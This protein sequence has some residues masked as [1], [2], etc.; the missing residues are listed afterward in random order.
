MTFEIRNSLGRFCAFAIAFA[1]VA[2]YGGTAL[3]E[4]TWTAPFPGVWHLHRG[5]TD[6][7]ENINVLAVELCHPGISFRATKFEERGQLTSSFGA[8]LEAQAAINGDF[9]TPGFGLDRGFAIGAGELWPAS[10]SSNPDDGS[11]GQLAIGSHRLELIPASVIQQP[12]PWMTQVVGGRPT[13]VEQGA[14][15]DTSGYGSLCDRNPRTAVGLTADKGLLIIAVVD[16]RADSRVGMTCTELGDLM[17][18][19]GARDALNLDGGGSSTMWLQGRGVLNFPTDGHER[20][21]GNHLAI[22]ASGQGPAA[23]CPRHRPFDSWSF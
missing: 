23:A 22:F 4:D 12:E 5:T 17:L 2:A 15:P 21:V 7:N 9:F 10:A 1:A 3:A 6:P 18:G 19:L 13:V 8:S 11:T 14:I 16:G 20:V